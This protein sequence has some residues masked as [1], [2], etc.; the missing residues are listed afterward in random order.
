MAVFILMMYFQ[1]GQ[2]LSDQTA[3][4]RDSIEKMVTGPMASSGYSTET[5]NNLV[6]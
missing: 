4:M 2:E 1:G 5:I 6:Y 3:N